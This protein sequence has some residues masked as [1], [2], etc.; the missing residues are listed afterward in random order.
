MADELTDSQ[1]D[2]IVA[3]DDTAEHVSWEFD[4]S[5]YQG[6]S[7]LGFA[8]IGD[9]DGR[10][11]FIQNIKSLSSIPEVDCVSESRNAYTVEVGALELSIMDLSSGYRVSVSNVKDYISGPE[12]QRLDVQER[13]N[14]LVLHRLQSRGYLRDSRVIT[15]ID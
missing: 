12:Y 3:L 7:T 8:H 14:E 10:C 6:P 2:L 13:L 5:N 4:A 11:S 15:R 9:I 1:Y